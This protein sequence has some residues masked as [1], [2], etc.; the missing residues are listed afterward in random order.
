MDYGKYP[1]DQIVVSSI[2]FESVP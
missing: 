2:A 1:Q